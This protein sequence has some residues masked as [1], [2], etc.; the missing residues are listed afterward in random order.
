M[1]IDP[2]EGASVTNQLAKGYESEF[3][4]KCWRV[5]H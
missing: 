4:D 5:E 1:K 3:G 2:S